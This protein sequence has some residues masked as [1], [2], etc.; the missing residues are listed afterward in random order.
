MGDNTRSHQSQQEN[1]PE[2]MVDSIFSQGRFL[3]IHRKWIRV[4]GYRQAMILAIL[5]DQWSY[6]RSRGRLQHDGSFF[7]VRQE[8]ADEMGSGIKD[9]DAGIKRLEDLNLLSGRMVGAPAKKFLLLNFDRIMK[10]LSDVPVIHEDDVIA[11]QEIPQ[12]K[13]SI[14]LKGKLA[15]LQKGGTDTT[16]TETTEDKKET[17]VDNGNAKDIDPTLTQSLDYSVK[18]KGSDHAICAREEITQAI[19]NDMVIPE[20][21]LPSYYVACI[22]SK[23]ERIQAILRDRYRRWPREKFITYMFDAVQEFIRE[24]PEWSPD[25]PLNNA[26]AI[27]QS[28]LFTWPGEKAVSP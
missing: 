21:G 2:T 15:S 4:I 17:T 10:I 18:D 23:P 12:E 28:N 19:P 14:P 24:H 25:H 27:K 5:I 22:K 9:I 6:W 8:I 13:H 16:S 7:K 11:Q 3:M 20:Q 1:T 26:N